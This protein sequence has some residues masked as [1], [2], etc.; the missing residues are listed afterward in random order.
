MMAAWTSTRY[1]CT[2]VA[3]RISVDNSSSN[4]SQSTPLAALAVGVSCSAAT[5]RAGRGSQWPS[6]CAV[7]LGATETARDHTSLS[8]TPKGTRMR[9]SLVLPRWISVRRTWS[10][11]PW[12]KMATLTPRMRSTK[13]PLATRQ[14][15]SLR[16][17]AEPN[18]RDRDFRKDPTWFPDDPVVDHVTDSHS[19]FRHSGQ[20]SRRPPQAS[21]RRRDR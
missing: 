20:S 10:R 14:T 6:P 5:K 13:D 16:L 15:A 4:A 11:S 17:K 3:E 7:Y 1:G 12:R 21:N 18:D 2:G 8:L 9:V 19:R